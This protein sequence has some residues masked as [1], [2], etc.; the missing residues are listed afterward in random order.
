MKR[1]RLVFCLCIANDNLCKE[2]NDSEKYE[3]AKHFCRIGE[4]FRHDGKRAVAAAA[5]YR[6]DNDTRKDDADDGLA[7]DEARR[8]KRTAAMRCF[9][10][11]CAALTAYIA[12]NEVAELAPTIRGVCTTGGR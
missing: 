5:G 3:K 6:H 10:C 1:K 11:R 9:L 4:I 8:H 7:Y 2:C 12:V